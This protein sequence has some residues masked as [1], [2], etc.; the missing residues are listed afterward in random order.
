MM[1]L[2]FFKGYYQNNQR[3]TYYYVNRKAKTN[4]ELIS[5]FDRESFLGTIGIEEELLTLAGVNPMGDIWI[6]ELEQWKD[7]YQLKEYYEKIAKLPVYSPLV[8]FG[9]SLCVFDLVNGLMF[10]YS[11]SGELLKEQQ[12]SFH[13]KK[14][15]YSIQVDEASGDSYSLWRKNGVVH[16]D[17]INMQNGTVAKTYLLK[18][19]INPE[20]VQFRKGQI[21][22]LYS[23]YNFNKKLFK[24]PVSRLR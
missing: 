23:D 15:V 24:M 9:E 19:Y 12:I 17:K 1:S 4:H 16:I 11:A 22:F 6:S 7:F 20:K 10:I 21:Y 13:E 8:Q 2:F 14:K 18:D 5:I 3:L